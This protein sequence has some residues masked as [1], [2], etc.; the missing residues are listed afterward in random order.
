MSRATRFWRYPEIQSTAIRYHHHPVRSRNSELAFAVHLANFAAKEAGF[1]TEGRVS[2]PE[3]DP[4]AL[5]Y[6]GFQKQDVSHIIAEIAASV[7]KLM[8]EFQ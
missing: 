6:L 2:P 1:K 8:I 3:I 5:S 7:D 4:Q